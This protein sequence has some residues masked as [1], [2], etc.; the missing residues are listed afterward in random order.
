QVRILDPACGTGNF[1][2]VSLDA[3]KRLENEALE[4]YEQLGGAKLTHYGRLVSPQQFLG[5]EIKRWAKEIAELVLWI[6]YLQW[7]V[8]TK[9]FEHPDEPILRDYHNIE[10]RDALLD[11]DEKVPLL[12]D[13]GRPVTRWDGV[14]MKRHPATGE[15]VPDDSARVPVYRYVNP[16]KAVWPEA[17]FIVGNPPFIGNFKMRAALSAGY[18]DALRYAV[19]HLP[20]SVDL[21][22][23]WWDEAATRVDAGHT[24]RAGFITTT[25]IT[26]TLNRRVVERHMDES[27]LVFAAADHPW[28]SAKY[29]Q[30]ARGDAEVRIAM[31]VLAKGRQS[32]VL[33]SAVSEREIGGELVADL[34]VK[35]GRINPNFTIGADVGTAVPLLANSGVSCPGVKLHGSGFLLPSAAA[36]KVSENASGGIHNHLRPYL[37][38][39]DIMAQSRGLYVIDFLGLN[40][41]TAR[42]QFPEMFEHVLRHVRPERAQNNREVYR[43]NWWL[44]GEPRKDFRP[45]LADLPRFIATPESARRRFFVFVDASVLPDNTIVAIAAADAYVLAILSSRVHVTW[46]LATGGR[47]GVRHDPRYNKTR[48]FETYPFPAAATEDQRRIRALGE[49][50]DAHR[51]AAQS[52]HPQLKLTKLYKALTALDRGEELDS[53]DIEAYEQGLG[54]TLKQLHDDLDA[55]VFDAYGWPHDLTDEEILERLVALNAERA[56]EERRGIIRWLRPE[57]QNPGGAAAAQQAITATGTDAPETAAVE[58][59]ARVWPKELPAQIAAVRELVAGAATQTWSAERTA[60]AVKGARRTQVEAVLESL[61]A[62]GLLIAIGEGDDRQWKSAA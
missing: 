35:H 28:L 33:A 51:K 13:E 11:Y 18:V 36:K 37:N 59:Q 46:A 10:C 8:R 54:A 45:A 5:I 58:K 41:E 3:L 57:F 30:A 15:E 49:T 24:R 31:S 60:R 27:S 16:R 22:M 19:R 26:H 55:A 43:R 12:D 23:Y 7:Q 44:F 39:Q 32:G 14:T 1:L 17:D 42:S 61:S 6:G 50:L 25:S 29:S 48:C 56:E 38:G 40:E 4:L 47:L 20:E 52:R 34:S 21:V 53:S 9:G 62:L 2:Y